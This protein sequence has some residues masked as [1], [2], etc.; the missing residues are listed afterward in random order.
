MPF[1]SIE[2]IDGSG[3][4]VQVN[5]LV[6]RLRA[7]SRSVVQTKE[8]DGGRLGKEVRAILTQ[9][10]RQL[11]RVEELLLVNAARYDHVQS[12][13]RPA[14]ARGDWVVSDRYFDSTYA[15]Q[16]FGAANDLRPLLDAVLHAV[17]GDARPQVTII[18]DLPADRAAARRTIRKD[19][20]GDPAEDRRNFVQIA[21]GFRSAA[22][23]DPG[24]CY[25]VNAD[26]TEEEVAADIWSR[27]APL[28]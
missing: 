12:V 25:L 11:E 17:V 24:R 1:V 10:D 8:P 28:L 21:D 27:I 6:E 22:A 2:G 9:N 18:L 4:S 3:K 19:S 26:R 20:L 23:N 7:E 16:V 5:R 15:L 13:I 14:L